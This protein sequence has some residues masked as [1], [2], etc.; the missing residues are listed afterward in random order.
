[1]PRFQED[2]FKTRT[3]DNFREVYEGR[4]IFVTDTSGINRAKPAIVLRNDPSPDGKMVRLTLLGPSPKAGL[5]GFYDIGTLPEQYIV[6]FESQAPHGFGSSKFMPLSEFDPDKLSNFDM[7]G[8]AG[9]YGSTIRL[10]R[11]N[12]YTI[13]IPINDDGSISEE[14][15]KLVDIRESPEHFPR[16]LLFERLT[17]RVRLKYSLRALLAGG[18]GFEKLLPPADQWRLNADYTHII[19]A[20]KDEYRGLK[21]RPEEEEA[22]KKNKSA[23]NPPTVPKSVSDVAEDAVNR[24]VVTPL[25]GAP[26]PPTVPKSVSDVAEDAVNRQVVTPLPGAP[27]PPTIPKSVSK[28]AEDAA[29]RKIVGAVTPPQVL[30]S[31]APRLPSPG[32]TPRL[33]KYGSSLQEGLRIRRIAS[34][35]GIDLSSLKSHQRFGK[36]E[37]IK[38]VNGKNNV[39]FR[40]YVDLFRKMGV[41]NQQDIENLA[42]LASSIHPLGPEAIF[43]DENM[44]E[45]HILPELQKL[46]LKEG[47]SGWEF[48]YRHSKLQNFLESRGY[49]IEDLPIGRDI[50]D[51][52]NLYKSIINRVL[53]DVRTVNDF[54]YE[55]TKE[56]SFYARERIIRNIRKQMPRNVTAALKRLDK[57]LPGLLGSAVHMFEGASARRNARLPESYSWVF[58][59]PYVREAT[60]NIWHDWRVRR[61]QEI[62]RLNIGFKKL[63]SIAEGFSSDEIQDIGES[64][65][66]IA[67]LGNEPEIPLTLKPGSV[68]ENY[69]ELRETRDQAT[70]EAFKSKWDSESKN[71]F[72]VNRNGENVLVRPVVG[73]KGLQWQIVSFEDY[74][75][76]FLGTES[77]VAFEPFK[78]TLGHNVQGL[79]DVESARDRLFMENQALSELLRTLRGSKGA[80][81]RSTVGSVY[82]DFLATRGHGLSSSEEFIKGFIDWLRLAGADSKNT[83]LASALESALRVF[84]AAGEASLDE[85]AIDLIEKLDESIRQSEESFLN[86]SKD[87]LERL[88]A[89]DI[90]SAFGEIGQVSI[91]EVAE[92][93]GE[94]GLN[95]IV[96]SYEENFLEGF[97]RNDA[98]KR[99]F[100]S[101]SEARDVREYLKKLSEHVSLCNREASEKLVSFIKERRQSSLDKLYKNFDALE[102][103]VKEAIEGRASLSAEFLL[104]SQPELFQLRNFKSMQD[105]II[106]NVHNPEML[107][108]VIKRYRKPAVEW[109]GKAFDKIV[110]RIENGQLRA[111]DVDFV[112]AFQPVPKDYPLTMS[113]RRAA[114]EASKLSDYLESHALKQKTWEFLELADALRR[115]KLKDWKSLSTESKIEYLESLAVRLQE[116]FSDPNSGAR[117]GKLVEVFMAGA[118]RDLGRVKNLGKDSEVERERIIEKTID[119]LYDYANV[120]TASRT[121]IPS[122]TL[123]R[124][125]SHIYSRVSAYSAV[126]PEV[127]KFPTLN[128]YLSQKVPNIDERLTNANAADLLFQTV[129]RLSE[130][131]TGSMTDIFQDRSSRIE[132][133]QKRLDEFRKRLLSGEFPQK[134][135]ETLVKLG[136]IDRRSQAQYLEL[137]KLIEELNSEMLRDT[138]SI[139]ESHGLQMEAYKSINDLEAEHVTQVELNTLN[140]LKAKGLPIERYINLGKIES[141]PIDLM[142]ADFD[143]LK[144]IG[145]YPE[146]LDVYHR[147]FPILPEK[148]EE[149]PGT[150][151][152]RIGYSFSLLPEEERNLIKISKALRRRLDLI[153]G[154]LID[155]LR[156][157]SEELHK[158]MNLGALISPI[159]GTRRLIE[160]LDE[161]DKILSKLPE[162]IRRLPK[163]ANFEASFKAIRNFAEKAGGPFTLQ[164]NNLDDLRYVTELLR[165]Y[166]PKGLEGHIQY[167]K[168]NIVNIDNKY[169]LKI[170]VRP[171]EYRESPVNSKPAQESAP[172]ESQ[173]IPKKLEPEF[174]IIVGKPKSGTVTIQHTSAKLSPSTHGPGPEERFAQWFTYKDNLNLRTSSHPEGT[175]AKGFIGK[176][177]IPW[178]IAEL[179]GEH[180]GED[181]VNKYV[182]YHFVSGKAREIARSSAP[183]EL[184][185]IAF[186]MTFSLGKYGNWL[187]PQDIRERE[188]QEVAKYI[189]DQAEYLRIAGKKLELTADRKLLLGN[190]AERKDEV[191]A[192]LESL[193]KVLEWSGDL[194]QLSPA[195][196][197]GLLESSVAERFATIPSQ[198]VD[199]NN[200]NILDVIESQ[201][202]FHYLRMRGIA[203]GKWFIAKGGGNEFHLMMDAGE[204]EPK[205][206]ASHKNPLALVRL[207]MALDEFPKDPQT[208]RVFPK[209]MLGEKIFLRGPVEDIPTEVHDFYWWKHLNEGDT[210]VPFG[211]DPT[212]SYMGLPNPLRIW[213]E[214]PQINEAQESS[215]QG[216]R[217]S[218]LN[219]GKS[220]QIPQT[221]LTEKPP[222][223]PI[224]T[225]QSTNTEA[226]KSIEI[227][228]PLENAPEESLDLAIIPNAKV[229]VAW[230]DE[231]SFGAKTQ[232]LNLI[233]DNLESAI[234]LRIREQIVGSNPISLKELP[235]YRNVKENFRVAVG[236]PGGLEGQIERAKQLEIETDGNIVRLKNG[237]ALDVETAGLNFERVLDVGA[238][239]VSVPG[240]RSKDYKKDFYMSP[241]SGD[242]N[243]AETEAAGFT[244]R[245]SAFATQKGELGQN[246]REA[247]RILGVYRFLKQ[248]PNDFIV[249]YNESADVGKLISALERLQK[250]DLGD[251]ISKNELAE[252]K[253]FLINAQNTRL[254]NHMVFEAVASKGQFRSLESVGHELGVLE[255]KEAHEG[256]LD[257]ML[258]I[259]VL[260]ERKKLISGMGPTEWERVPIEDFTGD[261]WF[262]VTPHRR[263]KNYAARIMLDG[264]DPGN[265]AIRITNFYE[266][267]RENGLRG[268]QLEFQE[269]TSKQSEKLGFEAKTSRLFFQDTADLYFFLERLNLLGGEDEANNVSRVVAEDLVNR[270][271]HRLFFEDRTHLE[272]EER[273]QLSMMDPQQLAARRQAAIEAGRRDLVNF[274]DTLGSD[275]RT[276]RQYEEIRDW[277]NQVYLEKYK[278]HLDNMLANVSTQEVIEVRSGDEI[279]TIT[280]THLDE[281]GLHRYLGE[282]TTFFSSL[283][284]QSRFDELATEIQR[285]IILAYTSFGNITNPGKIYINRPTSAEAGVI[286]SVLDFA[287]RSMNYGTFEDDRESKLLLSEALRGGVSA[288]TGIENP[289]LEHINTFLREGSYEQKRIIANDILRARIPAI[290]QAVQEML[291][292]RIY[293]QAREYAQQVSPSEYLGSVLSMAAHTNITELGRT[294]SWLRINRAVYWYRLNPG[295]EEIQHALESARQMSRRNLTH[296]LNMLS[297]QYQGMTAQ[298]ILARHGYSGLWGAYRSH[299]LRSANENGFAR[300][301]F[302]HDVESLLNIPD[303]YSQES[304]LI[305][306]A[307]VQDVHNQV[308]SL[309]ERFHGRKN[310]LTEDELRE[311]S[312]FVEQQR[313]RV[314]EE[315]QRNLESLR[316]RIFEIRAPINSNEEI[317]I[318]DLMESG[319]EPGVRAAF[320][321]RG[322]PAYL[323]YI[324]AYHRANQ[325]GKQEF[326]NTIVSDFMQSFPIPGVPAEGI[327]KATRQ[328]R[329]AI[330]TAAQNVSN[331]L[332]ESREI[333]MEAPV[334]RVEPV[335][336]VAVRPLSRGRAGERAISALFNP[337]V[338][339]I[340]I[341]IAVLTMG[342]LHRNAY[343]SPGSQPQDSGT[344][345]DRVTYYEAAQ[346]PVPQSM[347]VRVRATGP[348]ELDY[349]GLAGDLHR[350]VDTSYAGQGRRSTNIAYDNSGTEEMQV[351]QNFRRAFGY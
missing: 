278:P 9:S 326:V 133:A 298:Q 186:H 216:A 100:F 27:N 195:I 156:S 345:Q 80:E 22:L 17:P 105:D 266:T 230:K 149:I 59:S 131:L 146:F 48:V 194:D 54:I 132:V 29:K 189:N 335:P 66:R 129:S 47:G 77:N 56:H 275:M 276:R 248:R 90:K 44:F 81:A 161:A 313:A 28:N 65:R 321:Q 8:T 122:R 63:A 332:R 201:E 46:R 10:D 16:P 247:E 49:Y 319:G 290:D 228:I 197:Q 168:D 37:Q 26:N 176:E 182:L 227:L 42:F 15:V 36:N 351:R 203:R 300:T 39:V 341:P 214:I 302:I 200:K 331:Q 215:G 297:G 153:S 213:S 340:G 210:F 62:R 218:G 13:D 31:K 35:Y 258:T 98:F 252:A 60:R 181:E 24:Q 261:K 310:E 126:L 281:R 202:D 150:V 349:E 32:K 311:L 283:Y 289:T 84:G 83:K 20:Q 144:R 102:R 139:L 301:G 113:L 222:K 103:L 190:I 19:H 124:K 140:M 243:K 169:Y 64:S 72:V 350:V 1:M 52:V 259:N 138:R 33:R 180:A 108:K 348:K 236:L 299:I 5:P 284:P 233:D 119:I 322:L 151:P 265:R 109:L 154:Q 118:L 89:G 255:G 111:A 69:K 212:K 219:S 87:F 116:H 308:S 303:F 224:N 199:Q 143:L 329:E 130:S 71:L 240:E 295:E 336:P 274:I 165:L 78:I 235:V 136:V 114:E 175:S 315:V 67:G 152:K 234:P 312:S 339:A 79:I 330:A 125:I 45:E 304:A 93:Q 3:V 294:P 104:L 238:S 269:F 305:P 317:T 68:R 314:S 73:E 6:L 296:E 121:Q 207:M 51:V 55:Q 134:E 256:L 344:E 309:M 40:A 159:T 43:Q 167:N 115:T 75:K 253:E 307:T 110:T 337:Y 188:W 262:F 53:E 94:R 137:K 127:Q 170:S 285:P 30:D 263:D 171:N 4:L 148:L 99:G 141:A 221:P 223:P 173:L 225:D 293:D 57:V 257:A 191:L 187:V 338:L 292:E 92:T 273:M 88:S 342:I 58:N 192:H 184:A 164:V 61:L 324:L 320:G 272:F 107:L 226:S 280:Q 229:S 179:P 245:R 157:E 209:Q 286:N 112:I 328:A 327:S 95:R 18:F 318:R 120:R 232:E 123:I 306:D 21:W 250:E 38:R 242:F 25:P 128:E 23:P 34:V 343:Q 237:V 277:Y 260:A 86:P 160:L 74:A 241:K 85:R 346:N 50:S 251:A 163:Y 217:I 162:D 91:E 347:R 239:A 270:E 220:T 183:E 166:G 193:S 244:I 334:A 101:A 158:E 106:N 185:D 177:G 333:R 268:F 142:Q 172:K 282:K 206:V 147:V 178:I 11:R 70:L 135:F 211:V 231:A 96:G 287:R 246:L 76:Q 14:F 41:E 155:F 264:M 117:D 7:V 249:V 267:T 279:R 325:R 82:M 12:S 291:G 271:I 198:A 205:W 204:P 196:L 145:L 323:D 316:D 174:P 97:Y 2:K 208:W 288:Q 254:I